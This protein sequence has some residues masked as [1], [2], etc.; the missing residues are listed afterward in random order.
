MHLIFFYK[1]NEMRAALLLCLLLG[2][3]CFSSAQKNAVVRILFKA[4]PDQRFGFDACT[5][6]EW[7][8]HYSLVKLEPSETVRMVYKSVGYLESDRVDV[9]V[10]SAQ[11]IKEDKLQFY[12]KR[13]KIPYEKKNDSTYTILLPPAKGDYILAA[14][15]N[16]QLRAKLS[17]S[18]LQKLSEKV[19]V[20]PLQK[21]WL[22]EESLEEEVNAIFLQSNLHI[23]VSIEAPFKTKVFGEKTVF[24]TPSEKHDKYTGQMRL[25]RDL[26]FEAHPGADKKAYY[27]FLIPRFADS[28]GGYMVLNKPLAFMAAT[29]PARQ[30][31]RELARTLC[32]GIGIL[33]DSW[34][35]EGPEKGTTENLMDRG[36]GTQLTKV[37]WLALQDS[38]RNFSIYDKEEHVNTNNGIVAYYFWE[39]DSQGNIIYSSHNFL[40]TIKR[41]YKKNFLSYRFA[42][43]HKI[44][45]PFYKIGPYYLSAV[46]IF[47][48][49]I[50]VLLFLFIR[51]RK[52]RFFN[53]KSIARSNLW[54][55][56]LY[57][58]IL[59]VIAYLTYGSLEISNVI[60]NRFLVISGPLPELRNLD[61]GGAKKELLENPKLT[62]KEEYGLSSEILIRQGKTWLVKKRR[63]VLYFELK[64]DKQGKQKM[65]Y[66]LNSD[67]LKLESRN[68]N[69]KTYGHYLVFTQLDAAGKIL[70]QDVYNHRGIKV[71]ERVTLN[72]PPK[73]IL[74]F[75]NGYRPTSIGHTFEENFK[76]IRK[77]GLEHPNSKNLIYDFDRYDYW[78]QWNQINLLFRNRINAAETFYADGHFSVSTSNYKSILNFSSLSSVYPRRCPDP[79]KHSCYM[80]QTPNLKDKLLNNT[81]TINQLRLSSNKK[82][83]Y[84]RHR[85]GRLAGKNLLQVLN[86][87]PNRSENDTL[88]IVAHSMGF[89]YS[90]GIIEELRGKIRFGGFYIIAPENAKSGKISEGEWE[91]VWQYGSNFNYEK[92]DAPCLQDGV[93]PQSKVGGL[94]E[95]RRI[96]IPRALYLRKGFFDSHFIGYYTWVLDIPEGKKGFIRQR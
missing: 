47:V 56:L 46:N 31:A 54:R 78:E 50:I 23:D 73:R 40:E 69:E 10:R 22:E 33:D 37:Q 76:D 94:S 3:A 72:D 14:Y 58:P 67:S 17:V 18:V 60:L 96:Y 64:P 12:I 2:C 15:V 52:K 57:I 89:A 59:A 51:H 21:H 6:P 95:D 29:F 85:K 63:K 7:K 70:K 66:V 11:K 1:P 16:K 9:V 90:L 28:S 77:K 27:V 43:S 13:D 32:F 42:V 55:R 38:A 91:E 87:V 5:H 68:Y 20:V 44:L 36:E 4:S 75:V 34:A 39:E 19:I 88:F 26:Y 79:R 65:R 93:A 48:L 24:G 83:F 80:W 82:G 53:R 81:Q 8:K 84:L 92:Y 45:M 30:F 35:D 25:L 74:L 49:G 41:P 71:S 61:Y 62:R 86:E